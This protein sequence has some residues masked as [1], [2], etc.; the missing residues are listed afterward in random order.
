MKNALLQFRMTGFAVLVAA[1]TLIGC[2]SGKA[3]SADRLVSIAGG[4][5]GGPFHILATGMAKLI[6]KYN[7]DIRASAEVTGGTVE[8]V[9]LAGTKKVTFALSQADIAFYA[10][11]GGPAFKGKERYEIRALFG[12]HA[13]IMHAI[14]FADSPIKS[15][16]DFKG[17][18]VSVGQPGGGAELLSEIVLN[19]YG[20]KRGKDYTPEF[21]SIAET[22]SGLKDG[23]IDA[24]FTLTGVPTAALR[25]ASIRRP[26]RLLSVDA[27]ILGPVLK[28]RP[29][30]YLDTIK[31]DSYNG[32]QN[33]VQTIAMNAVIVTHKDTDL[34]LIYDITKAILEHVDELKAI[35]RSG[36]EYT[37]SRAVQ[38]PILLHPGAEKYLKERG[39]LK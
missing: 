17:K 34:K 35:H 13:S 25:E 31:A 30:W 15:L 8:N 38:V 39:A 16:R 19:A 4:A 33:D 32:Q 28:E 14:V 10:L 24:G 23:S 5:A 21:L 29:Y 3:Y 26:L 37:L 20:L 22:G 18:R 36:G 9:R 11:N 2:Q 1:G 12:G 27:N 7:P 6:E